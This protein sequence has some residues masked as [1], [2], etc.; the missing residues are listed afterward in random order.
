MLDTAQA[1][2]CTRHDTLYAN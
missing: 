2:Q 1:R